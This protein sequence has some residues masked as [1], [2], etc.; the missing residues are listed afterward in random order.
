MIPFQPQSRQRTSKTSCP[1]CEP[2][3][4]VSLALH[5]AS[6]R[7][8]NSFNITALEVNLPLLCSKQVMNGTCPVHVSGGVQKDLTLG[9]QLF[10]IFVELEDICGVCLLLEV[11]I[12][13]LEGLKRSQ[14]SWLVH[15]KFKA[16]YM[17]TLSKQQQRF[18]EFSICRVAAFLWLGKAAFSS[19]RS[20]VP[21][22]YSAMCVLY[23]FRESFCKVTQTH[24]READDAVLLPTLWSLEQ[25][26]LLGDVQVAGLQSTLLAKWSNKTCMI[27]LECS[28]HKK[29]SFT[30]VHVLNCH[31]HNHSILTAHLLHQLTNLRLTTP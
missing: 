26:A 7:H 23:P 18:L 19:H 4:C 20:S 25:P 30:V 11:E 21:S 22:Q 15:R 17:A 6:E 3:M 9:L 27:P 16:S 2:Q 14:Q 28:Q 5:S 31:C 10:V 8:V 29:P 24:P 13:S 12:A 1:A